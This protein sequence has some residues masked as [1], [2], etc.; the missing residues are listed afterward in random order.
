MDV[1]LAPLDRK[2]TNVLPE[3]QKMGLGTCFTQHCNAIADQTGNKTWVPAKPSSVKLLRNQGF[4]DVAKHRLAFG[5]L[6]WN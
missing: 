6:W 4:K 3:F 2:G 5:A 1:E